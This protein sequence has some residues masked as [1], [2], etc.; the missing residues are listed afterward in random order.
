MAMWSRISGAGSP[1][2]AEGS[3]QASTMVGIGASG[4]GSKSIAVE[5]GDEPGAAAHTGDTEPAASRAG[6]VV[7][8]EGTE[9][10]SRARMVATLAGI[11]RATTRRRRSV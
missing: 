11:G 4:T 9:P 3:G 8:T 7:C 10:A 6:A 2:F 5:G 1:V